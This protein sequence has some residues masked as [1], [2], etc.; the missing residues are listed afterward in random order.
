MDNEPGPSSNES[1]DVGRLRKKAVLLL[2]FSVTL[3]ASMF[4]IP[5]GTLWYWE[6]WTLIGTL[7]LPATGVFVYLLKK[8]PELLA[9]RLKTKEK[10][11]EQKSLMKYSVWFFFLAFLL[12]GFDKR[13]GWSEV[14][15]W[16]ALFAD[17]LVF[18][19]YLLFFYVIRENRYASRVVEVEK[20]QTVIDTGPYSIVRHPMYVS[21]LLIYSLAPLALGSFWAVPVAAGGI[22]FILARRIR[23]EED[24]LMRDLSGYRE[25]MAR[26]RYRLIPGIW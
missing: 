3:L 13:F 16:L 23:N 24:V 9:R 19:G 6:A 15:W 7:V 14:P 4:C 26:T 20:E 10:E 22:L 17:V 8:D 5:A 2:V 21:N 18:L 12:P 1:V 25:Y 11:K